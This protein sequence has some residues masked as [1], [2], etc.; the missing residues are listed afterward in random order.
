[1]S[2]PI[3]SVEHLATSYGDLKVVRDVSF[4]VGAGQV[5]ALLGRN[6]A[7]KTTTLRAVA[8][9]N[10]VNSGL[11]QFDGREISKQPAHRR[12][13]AGLA[14]VQEGK[15]IF[16]GRT[17]EENLKLGGTPARL[18]GQQ[19]RVRI[20][21]AYER[22]PAL[23]QRR[24]I[25]ASALSG[26]QQQMLAIAQAL[27]P[28]P[29]VLLLD[30]PSGGLAPSIVGEVLST[31]QTL[32]NEGLAVVLVEQAVSFALA[33]ADVVVVLDQGRVALS[34][35]ADAENLELSIQSAYF[36]ASQ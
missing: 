23:A 6:G 7:G 30:E 9:L 5:V 16:R 14:Y 17:V 8:G 32:V 29:S 36:A 25:P 4:S 33:L 28:S 24:S 3:L 11:V 31:V 22:F 18:R 27:I 13:R 1:M 20:D 26:G 35:D 10:P 12:S 15:R 21:E 34:A 19:L 2:T